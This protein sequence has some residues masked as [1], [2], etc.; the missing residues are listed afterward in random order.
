MTSPYIWKPVSERA[1]ITQKLIENH[2][3]NVDEIIEV[4]LRSR[5][6]IFS[7]AIWSDDFYIWKDI[8][9]TPQIMWFFLH[10]LIPL[11]LSKI[12]KW[13]RSKDKNVSDKDLVYIPD[14]TYS[15]EIKTSSQKWLYWNRSYAHEWATSKKDKSWYY[16]WVNFEKFQ[17]S[18]EPQKTEINMIRFWRLDHADWSWQAAQ[19]WQQSSLSKDVLNNKLLVIYKK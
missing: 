13:I 3:L 19:T 1:I 5:N 15:I 10:E 17:N 9:P 14:I 8:F 7:S 6:D 16:L 2:P 18:Q 12:Y 11:N 4:V